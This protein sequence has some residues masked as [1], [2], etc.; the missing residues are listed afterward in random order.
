MRISISPQKC[1]LAAFFIR[2]SVA[3]APSSLIDLMSEDDGPDMQ[4]SE[5]LVLTEVQA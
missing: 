3:A 5:I 1:C 4:M 2:P